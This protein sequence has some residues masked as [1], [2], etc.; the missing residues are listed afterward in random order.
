MNASL[1]GLSAVVLTA[2]LAASLPASANPSRGELLSG[3]E[4]RE[5]VLRNRVFLATPLGGEFPIN[6]RASG[7]VDGSGEAI[8]LGRFVQPKD[9]GRW[10]ISGNSLCQQW[11]SWYDGKRICFTIERVGA[12]A[13]IWR[14][15]N[16]DVGRARLAER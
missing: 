15:D 11:E 3:A 13:I 6:Y 1:L 10:W 16:G 7:Q 2:G 4:I 12:K 8:G 5:L 9:K 14:Q